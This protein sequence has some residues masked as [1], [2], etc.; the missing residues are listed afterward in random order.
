MI[1]V[2]WFHGRDHANCWVLRIWSSKALIYVL[3]SK[4]MN[5]NIKSYIA[6][7]CHRSQNALQ[8]E[9]ILIIPTLQMEKLRHRWSHIVSLWQ[10]WFRTQESWD[11]TPQVRLH[12]LPST[13]L[14][15]KT[16]ILH[17]LKQAIRGS[18]QTDMFLVCQCSTTSCNQEGLANPE[19]L[20][21]EAAV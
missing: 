2:V 19:S 10:S 12:S 17:T 13:A 3:N 8:T 5:N 14:P 16:T 4:H 21:K 1:K 7:F 15:S 11:S 6:F 20:S 18:I 9:E